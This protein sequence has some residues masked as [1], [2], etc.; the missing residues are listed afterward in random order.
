MIFLQSVLATITENIVLE[1]S[2][3]ISQV[4]TKYIKHVQEKE[5]RYLMRGSSGEGSF[6]TFTDKNPNDNWSAI[7]TFNP[8]KLKFKEHANILLWYTDQQIESGDFYNTNGT[9]VGIMAG[10]EFDSASAQIILAINDGLNYSD[11]QELVLRETLPLKYHD[12]EMSLKLIYTDKNLKIE[13]YKE[14]ELIHDALRFYK[15]DVLGDLGKGK[16]FSI[17]TH[18]DNVEVNKHLILSGFKVFSRTENLTYRP[19]LKADV[20][21]EINHEVENAISHMEHFMGY[22]KYLM[23]E[24]GGFTVASAIRRLVEDIKLEKNRINSFKNT[25]KEQK[26]VNIGDLGKK[27]AEIDMQMLVAIR[28]INELKYFL[29]DL[30]KDHD[31]NSKYIIFALFLSLSILICYLVF[32]DLKKK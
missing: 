29:L 5:D 9:F 26:K 14:K 23:G 22:F 18:Y 20:R 4:P 27:I 30:E 2:V 19:R 15:T 13:I 3:P 17:S 11:Y 12:G 16:H 7:M 1:Y 8:I 21:Y 10:I 31:K 24:P 25:L 28:T 6:I 32:G